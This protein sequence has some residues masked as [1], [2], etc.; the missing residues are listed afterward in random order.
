MIRVI[1]ARTELIT[2]EARD[3]DRLCVRKRSPRQSFTGSYGPTL[4]GV[5]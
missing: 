4:F 5:M 3:A 1:E 2:P